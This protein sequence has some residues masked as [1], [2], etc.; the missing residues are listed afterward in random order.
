[1]ILSLLAELSLTTI[2][3]PLPELI[4]MVIPQPPLL[5]WILMAMSLPLLELILT[6]IPQPPLPEWILTAM[7][8]PL[9]P[10]WTGNSRRKH[11]T[12][13]PNHWKHYVIYY[14]SKRYPPPLSKQ[15]ERVTLALLINPAVI[16]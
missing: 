1:M 3:P 12:K 13:W 16:I 15:P 5:E 4:Q 2:P 7:P 9:L 8:L 14:S 6:A 11:T 10:E